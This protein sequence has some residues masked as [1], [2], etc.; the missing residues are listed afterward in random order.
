MDNQPKYFGEVTEW[1]IDPLPPLPSEAEFFA[2]KERIKAE[3]K[4][5]KKQQ[6]NFTIEELAQRKLE[7]NQREKEL[8]DI[9]PF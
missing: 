5:L 2:E 8:I 3:K 7:Q 9:L 1:L 6:K 4:E